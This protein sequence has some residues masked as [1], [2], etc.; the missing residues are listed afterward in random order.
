M[1]PW[2]SFSSSRAAAA[3]RSAS[4]L[5]LAREA[6]AISLSESFFFEPGFSE[7]SLVSGANLTSGCLAFLAD[8]FFFF[9][10]L[11]TTS[12]SSAVVD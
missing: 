4:A 3:A 5:D 8:A 9:E 2:S 11:A 10:E 12:G 6:V 7:G 1:T